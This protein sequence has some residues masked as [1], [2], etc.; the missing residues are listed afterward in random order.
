MVSTS[1]TEGHG[2]E[3]MRESIYKAL[4]IVRVYTK[5][6][7]SKADLTEPVILKRGSTTIDAAES[8][9]KDF[10]QNLRYIV[11]W[12]SG[13]YDGQRVGRDHALQDGDI[14]EFHV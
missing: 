3:K 5:A 10:Q 14:V 12:G 11:I 6:P 2:L 4:D 13:K 1:A 7:G 8:V 9:H